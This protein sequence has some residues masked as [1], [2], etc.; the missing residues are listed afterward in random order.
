MHRIIDF[1]TRN[2]LWLIIALIAILALEPAVAEIK[3]FFIVCFTESLALALSGAAA[4]AYTRVDFA[5]E[6]GGNALGFIFLGAHICVG[7]TVLGVYIAQ[8]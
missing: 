4:F 8:F 2:G 6:R 7:L 3:T 5:S 1:I